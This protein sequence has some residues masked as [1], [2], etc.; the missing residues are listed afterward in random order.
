MELLFTK[1]LYGKS[2]KD[3][4][5]GRKGKYL[6]LLFFIYDVW[7]AFLYDRTVPK[8]EATFPDSLE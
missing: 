8:I 3:M 6:D 7:A 2:L 1:K 5:N 4:R